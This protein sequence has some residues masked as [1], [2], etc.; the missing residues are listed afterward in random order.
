MNF[1]RK[2][3]EAAKSAGERSGQ[4]FRSRLT[5][6]MAVLALSSLTVVSI[7]VMSVVSKDMQDLSSA[8]FTTIAHAAAIASDGVA[9]SPPYIDARTWLVVTTTSLA[10]RDG[11]DVLGVVAADVHIDGIAEMAGKLDMPDDSHLFIVDSQGGILGH[12]D[13]KRFQFVSGRPTRVDECGIPGYAGLVS[14][15][16]IRCRGTSQTR[17]RRCSTCTSQPLRWAQHRARS[18]SSSSYSRSSISAAATSSSLR[19]STSIS[20]YSSRASCSSAC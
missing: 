20:T 18:P 15:G 13:A 7:A 2:S 1:F 16:E 14:R 8:K 17:S 11:D 9:S 12:R 3:L 5:V 6:I 4:R 19:T 10:V